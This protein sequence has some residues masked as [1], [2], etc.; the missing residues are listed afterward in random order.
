MLL[1]L[2]LDKRSSWFDLLRDLSEFNGTNYSLRYAGDGRRWS[3][4]SMLSFSTAL[5][6]N[7]TSADTTVA[8]KGMSLFPYAL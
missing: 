2:P 7:D 8:A 1:A 6:D 3:E 5:M 4:T